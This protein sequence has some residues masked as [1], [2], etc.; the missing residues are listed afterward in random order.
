MHAAPLRFLNAAAWPLTIWP[1]L[2]RLE[3]HAADDYVERTSPIVATAI[4]F[5]ACVAALLLVAYL[6]GA[7][8]VFGEADS[9]AVVPRW[10][11]DVSGVL[12]FF[13]PVI[14]V[15]GLW[16]YTARDEAFPR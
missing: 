11:G 10:A 5:W 3:D 1:S 7:V 12:W 4:A 13:L 16:L 6:G 15:I 8:S 2:T 14:Y 9:V